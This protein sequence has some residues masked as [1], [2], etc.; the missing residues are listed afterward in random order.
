MQEIHKQIKPKTGPTALFNC[1][2]CP[3]ADD[4]SLDEKLLDLAN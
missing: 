4:E 1:K 2:Y 3:F